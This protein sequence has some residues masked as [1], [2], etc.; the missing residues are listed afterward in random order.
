MIKVAI[1]IDTE[2]DKMNLKIDGDGT[3]EEYSLLLV[4][5]KIMEE[6][7]MEHIKEGMTYAEELK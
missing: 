2:K 4:K 5:M 7:I 3:I 1:I 6:I